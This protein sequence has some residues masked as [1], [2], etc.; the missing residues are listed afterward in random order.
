MSIF[1]IRVTLILVWLV[2]ISILLWFLYTMIFGDV[3][4]DIENIKTNYKTLKE[5]FKKY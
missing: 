5:L 2:I 1:L 4:A 3:K